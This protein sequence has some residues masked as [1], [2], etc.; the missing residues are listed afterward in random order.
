MNK[1]HAIKTERETW[2]DTFFIPVPLRKFSLILF[3]LALKQN[4]FQ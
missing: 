3:S 4:P 1:K 2:I